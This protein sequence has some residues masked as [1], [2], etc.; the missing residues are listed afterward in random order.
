ML[1]SAEA[2]AGWSVALACP[3]PSCGGGPGGGGRGAGACLLCP[4][5]DGENGACA[6]AG[7][8]CCSFSS[9]PFSAPMLGAEGEGATFPLAVAA[10]MMLG[11]RSRFVLKAE[12]EAES[13]RARSTNGLFLF[14]G[15]KVCVGWIIK[16]RRGDM[17]VVSMRVHAP[18]DAVDPGDGLGVHGAVQIADVEVAG[19]ALALDHVVI[20]WGDVG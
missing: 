19:V 7:G 15:A 11:L 9:S 8:G 2:R 13:A 6:R 14:V 17:D 20:C 10:A 4:D 16:K 3:C 1:S 18:E 12:S 5:K